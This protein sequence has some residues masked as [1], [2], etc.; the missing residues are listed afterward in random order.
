MQS[1][2]THRTTT[3]KSLEVIVPASEVDAEYNEVIAKISGK[4]KIPGF[5]PGKASKDVIL[6]RYEREIKSEVAESL[7]KKHFMSA[8]ETSKVQPISRPILENMELIEHSDGKFNIL[9]D[10]APEVVVPEYKNI[11]LT[12]KKRRISEDDVI[13]QLEYIRQETAK[14]MPSSNEF[15][16]LNDYVTMDVTVKPQGLKTVNYKDQV[17]QL[18]ADRPFDTEI[19]NTKVNETKTFS[20]TIPADDHNDA[21]AGKTMSYTVTIKDLRVRVLSEINDDFA[22]DL[23]SYATL[24][25]LKASILVDLENFAEKDAAL[26]AHQNIIEN[27]LDTASFEVPSSMVEL[28]LD[29]YCHEFAKLVSQQG[30]DPK[31]ISWEAYGNSRKNE[32]ERIVRSSYILQDIGNT[33]NIQ[34]T[35]EE[36][37]EEIENFMKEHKVQKSFE[38]FRKTI[39]DNG[40]IDEIKGRVCTYKTLDRILSFATITEELLDKD[41][42]AAFTKSERG[43]SFNDSESEQIAES[44]DDLAKDDCHDSECDNNCDKTVS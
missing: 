26:R 24:D 31:K 4:I 42:F 43:Q 25:E 11:N 15:A 14:L 19:L 16:Q 3:R 38:A 10:V 21:M 40:T 22:K 28:Q 30:I 17:I 12:K 23:G 20:I 5:R 37:N 32:A 9:F 39:E 35:D 33:E 8:A 36:V 41:A 6:S 29:K 7:I 27:L 1:N 18:S 2:L 13:E 44:A 34:A